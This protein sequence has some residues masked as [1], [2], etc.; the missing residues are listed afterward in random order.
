MLLDVQSII[1]LT[2]LLV[3][4]FLSFLVHLKSS[5]L[6]YLLKNERCFTTADS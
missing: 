6:K 5:V 1:S 4:V 3:S 2:K